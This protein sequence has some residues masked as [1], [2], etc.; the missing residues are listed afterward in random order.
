M[1]KNIDVELHSLIIELGKDF[2]DI[3]PKA[4]VTR[5]TTTTKQINWMSSKLKTSK[6]TIKKVKRQPTE[7]KLFAN[8]VYYKEHLFRIKNSF[9]STIKRQSNL[10]LGK[11]FEQTYLL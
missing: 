1:K 3:T 2:L 8:H 10:K 7:Q 4:Q 6:H 11:I 5:T 9:N